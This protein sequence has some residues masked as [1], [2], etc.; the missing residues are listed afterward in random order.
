M[1]SCGMRAWA[2]RRSFGDVLD[3]ARTGDEE[4]FAALWRW[5]HTPLLRW[6][7]VVAPGDVE[8]IES[9]VW[10]SVARNLPTF[11]GDDDDFRGWVFTIAR[12]RAI[13]WGR[14]RQRRPTAVHLDGVDLAD[15][16]E[17]RSA[18]D[19]TAAALAIMRG[20]PSD[21]REALALR[22]IIGMSVRETATVLGRSEG[23]VR[24]LCHRGLHA[25]QRQVQAD[26][27]PD[28]VAP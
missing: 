27:A 16:V 28:E 2:G 13:D 26:R 5:L 20:L 23:S 4:S 12:R 21:Q 3:A 6:L 9:E 10:L 24:V 18:D 22:V 25:L 17:Q 8:D 7:T 14:R 15:P 11:R 1:M 19:E